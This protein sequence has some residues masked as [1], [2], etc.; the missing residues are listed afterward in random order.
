MQGI[1]AD[2]EAR[3]NKLVAD[4]RQALETGARADQLRQLENRIADVNQV[5]QTIPVIGD[6][7]ASGLDPTKTGAAVAS[8]GALA[9]GLWQRRS[10]QHYRTAVTRYMSKTDAAESEKLLNEVARTAAKVGT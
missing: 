1:K 9:W 6:A 8:L 4:Y 10:V 7:V 2:L 3:E 5:R